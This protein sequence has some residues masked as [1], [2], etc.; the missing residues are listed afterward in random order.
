MEAKV[1]FI[2]PDENKLIRKEEENANNIY[3][4]YLVCLNIFNVIKYY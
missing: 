3:L 2:S 1:L 4:V